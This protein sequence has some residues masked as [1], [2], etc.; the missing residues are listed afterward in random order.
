MRKIKRRNGW[1]L[2]FWVLLLAMLG[3]AGYV[4]FN[5]SRPVVDESSIEAPA[6]ENT[7]I[8]DVTLTKAQVNRVAKNYIN[9]FLSTDDIRYRLK[10][11]NEQANVTGK[12]NFLGSDIGFALVLEPYMRVNGDVQ[13]KAQS[14]KIGAFSLPIG[15]VMNYIG[16]SYHLPKWVGLDSRNEV[17]NLNLSKY[18]PKNGYSYKVKKLDLPGDQIQIEVF[19][20]GD[21]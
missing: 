14:L 2:A 20:K 3:G 21:K 6:D 16:N 7:A 19:K 18:H 9:D 13:L 1:K 4:F 5:V 12:L 15:F 10:L 8:F 17:I 11:E